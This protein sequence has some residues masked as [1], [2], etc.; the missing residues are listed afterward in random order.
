MTAD[1]YQLNEN[2]AAAASTT[3]KALKPTTTAMNQRSRRAG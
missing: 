2:N 3:D 1:F